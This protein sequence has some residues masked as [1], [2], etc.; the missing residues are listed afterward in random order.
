MIG[1]ARRNDAAESKLPVRLIFIPI[2]LLYCTLLLWGVFNEHMGECTDRTYPNIFTYQ[3]AVFFM[4]YIGFLLLHSRNYFLVWHENIRDLHANDS[5]AA[6]LFNNED[7]RRLRVKIIFEAQCERFKC[8]FNWLMGLTVMALAIVIYQLKKNG[9][10]S[11]GCSADGNHWLFADCS[12][13]F[14][15]Q[16]LHVFTTMQCAAM[17]RVVFIKTV[18]KVEE[19]TSFVRFGTMKQTRDNHTR[20]THQQLTIPL[21]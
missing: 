3:Y 15:V 18:K 7:R 2:H 11:V 12:A 5:T 8:F 16:F 4:T 21:H 14:F 20:A 17:A 6:V 13:R 1:F 9:G 10:G 19:N